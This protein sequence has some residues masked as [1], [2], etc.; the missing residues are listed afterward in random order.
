[1]NNEKRRFNIVYKGVAALNT[2][3]KCNTAFIK[4]YLTSLRIT[5]KI[6]MF[7]KMQ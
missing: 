7:L 3:V 2:S 5:T 6:E 1:M 4:S